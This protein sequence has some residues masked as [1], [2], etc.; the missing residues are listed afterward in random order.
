MKVF[1]F[2]PIQQNIHR[3][4]ELLWYA[5][6]ALWMQ[7]EALLNILWAF[8]LITSFMQIKHGV[9]A[10]SEYR[11]LS[12]SIMAYLGMRIVSISYAIAP[13]QA[14]TAIIDDLRIFSI[15]IIAISL[16]RT[17]EQLAKSVLFS[18]I[19]FLFLGWHALEIQWSLIHG[20]ATPANLNVEFGSLAHM[21]YAAAFSSIII[22]TGIVAWFHFSHIKW[23]ILIALLIIPL[24]LMQIPLSSRTTMLISGAIIALFLIYKLPIIK[25]F[26]FIS[27]CAGVVLFSLWQVPGGIKQ[28]EEVKQPQSAP[29]VWIRVDVWKTLIHITESYPF[30]IGPRGFNSIDLNPYKIWMFENINRTLTHYYPQKEIEQQLQFTDMNHPHHLVTDPHS[31]Y[32]SIYAENGIIGLLLFLAWLGAMLMLAIQNLRHSDQHVRPF[33][34]A[35]LGGLVIMAGCAT[36]TALF[37]QS[38]GIITILLMAFLISS[39]RISHKDNTLA[40]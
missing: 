8:L 3:Y 29:S 22:F 25:A 12:Y 7:G 2:T 16:I 6:L 23:K 27:V 30:G 35:M 14:L 17:Q 19:G 20:L 24:A 31:H 5:F 28:F 26:V 11:W 13:Y 9:R 36:M 37:Y 39:L 40:S 32:I 33:A 15:G 1:F 34:E 10:L 18:F 4:R 21:N 38:G